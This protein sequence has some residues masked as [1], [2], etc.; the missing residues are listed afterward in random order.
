MASYRARCSSTPNNFRFDC[1]D[2][3][4]I[5]H[6][7]WDL[8]GVTWTNLHS[9]FLIALSKCF[10]LFSS[11]TLPHVFNDRSFLVFCKMS[12][13][14][15]VS[16]SLVYRKTTVFLKQKAVSFVF[17]FP[18]CVCLRP[19]KTSTLKFPQNAIFFVH[20]RCV[21]TAPTKTTT[22]TVTTATTTTT[23]LMITEVPVIQRVQGQNR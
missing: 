11:L 5:R 2:E 22:T 1:F 21:S 16:R 12:V 4:C 19:K 3:I 7:I 14:Q 8:F 18:I 17:I 10:H 13:S 20:V 6:I 15:L 23:S 9:A